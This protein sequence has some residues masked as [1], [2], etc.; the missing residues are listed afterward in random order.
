MRTMRKAMRLMGAMVGTALALSGC[1]QGPATAGRN[2]DAA[3]VVLR[4]AADPDANGR[5]PVAVD[6]VRAGDTAMAAR[7]GSMDAAS[8]FHARDTL[9]NEGTARI[10]IV[11]W[12]VVP[13]QN[14]ALGSLPP[15]AATPVATFVYALYAA[16]G[17]HRQRVD[18]GAPLAVRLGRDGFTLETLAGG[19]VP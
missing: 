14:V 15:F 9:R 3:P 4:I 19:G 1:A 17:L 7:L 2:A 5:R 10:A 6:V 12:E 18:G 8:W 13:G 16:P 11:S